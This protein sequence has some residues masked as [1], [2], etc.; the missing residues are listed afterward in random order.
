[1]DVK[2]E[3]S[4]FDRFEREHGEYDVLGEGAYSR[5]LA[6]FGRVGRPTRQ[7][8]VIDLGCGSGAFTRRLSREFGFQITGMDVS[9][10]LID[11]A[12]QQGSQPTYLVG[13]ITTTGLPGEGFDCIVYSGV[14]HHFDAAHTRLQVLREGLRILRPGGLLFGYDPSWHSPAMWLYRSPDS[15][16][17]SNKGKTENE[18]L[19]KRQ[20]LEAELT[21]AGFVDIYIRGVAGITFRYVASRSARLLLPLYNLYELALRFSPLE[22]RWGT[23]LVSCARKSCEKDPTDACNA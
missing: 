10:R 5:L 11:Q 21:S 19:L 12:I 1:M 6:L 16:L 4:F 20:E 18:V 9:P 14:L 7:W 2:N 8:K 3:V 17:Y 15:P 23:F 13:D 22:N